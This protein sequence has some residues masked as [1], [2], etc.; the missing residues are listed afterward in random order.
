MPCS[1]ILLFA[2]SVKNQ[3][4]HREQYSSRQG[5]LECGEFRLLLLWEEPK[6]ADI[7]A[8]VHGSAER[9]RR[10]SRMSTAEPAA[11]PWT[12]SNVFTPADRVADARVPLAYWPSR[13]PVY[14][15]YAVRSLIRSR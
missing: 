3:L 2:L 10:H 9:P 13:A 6:S 1:Q 15:P 7:H 11:K 8:G 5:I 14:L 4:A 12:Y